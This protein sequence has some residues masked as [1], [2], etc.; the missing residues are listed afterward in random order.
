MGLLA[1]APTIAGAMFGAFAYDALWAVL[2]LA[3]GAGAI[4]QVVIE[5]TRYQIKQAGAPALVG[6][7]S[8]AGFAAGLA[9]MYTTGLFVTM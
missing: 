2:F 7:Y 1:G 6:G 9:V 5:I 8:L 4:I 3:I